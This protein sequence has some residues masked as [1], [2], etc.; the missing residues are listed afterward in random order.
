MRNCKFFNVNHLFYTFNHYHC[1]FVGAHAAIKSMAFSNETIYIYIYICVCVQ[2][3]KTTSLL[4]LSGVFPRNWK[5]QSNISTNH[6]YLQQSSFI[7]GD[8]TF[9]FV[10]FIYIALFSLLFSHN[11]VY[12]LRGILIWC[13]IERSCIR[14]LTFG[15]H[16]SADAQW[17]PRL[18]I[19]LTT[20][21]WRF[22]FFIQCLSWCQMFSKI[23]RN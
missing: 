6:F 15:I 23:R 2:Q 19:I 13:D 12:D 14:M 7:W 4:Y 9:Y 16:V 11:I 17:Y 21:F 10:T 20:Y 5:Q 8:A 3:S 1:Q 22:S 18:V